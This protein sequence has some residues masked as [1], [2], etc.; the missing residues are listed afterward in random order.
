MQRLARLIVVLSLLV[1]TLSIGLVAAENSSTN[2]SETEPT[3]T[4]EARL[5]EHKSQFK[6]NLTRAAQVIIKSKCKAS[7]GVISS[8]SGRIKGIQTS[9]SAVY[10][11]ITEHLSTLQIKL[12]N[13]NV[14]TTELQTEI[15]DLQTK[16]DVYKTD[17]TA[18]KQAVADLAAMDCMSD[19][20]AFRSTLD[21]ARAARQKVASDIADIR[22]YVTGTIKP[23]LVKIRQ[24]LEANQPKAGN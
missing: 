17:I 11:N 21:A 9:R 23:T 20:A 5:S 14:D 7:Q 10:K 24:N 2:T 22:S 13:K 16:I 19:P 3:T 12:Q 4:L 6:E 15:A 18:Y 8:L 1:P